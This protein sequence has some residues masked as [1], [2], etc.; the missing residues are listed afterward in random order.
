MT[1]GVSRSPLY[2]LSTTWST[3]LRFTVPH[4]APCPE[5]SASPC[6]PAQKKSRTTDDYLLARLEHLGQMRENLAEKDYA[7]I[8]FANVIRDMLADVH[9][10]YKQD[11]KFKMYQALL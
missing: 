8:W 9:P 5:P 10:A 11:L 6:T 3:G 2:Q 1:S 7:D 4:H